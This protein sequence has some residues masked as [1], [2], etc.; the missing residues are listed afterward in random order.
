MGGS[1]SGRSGWRP[2]VENA[3]KL[4][5]SKFHKSGYS[6]G[7]F[8]WTNTS[9][10]EQ[11]ASIGYSMNCN[12]MT[13]KLEYTK[14]VDGEKNPVNDTIPLTIQKTGF[15]GSRFLF[16]CPKCSARVA[17]LYLPNG[18]LYFRCRKCY[19]LTYQSSNDSGKFNGLF[20]HIA[21]NTGLPFENVKRILKKKW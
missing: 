11:V 18:A 9:T 7:S 21:A 4:D 1:G 17:K 16:L 6:Y 20:R 19:N 8:E 3:L 12:N 14:T 10:G 13:I 2:V 5:S 15:K